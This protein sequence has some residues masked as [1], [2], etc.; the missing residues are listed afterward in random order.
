MA[1]LVGPTAALPA[2]SYSCESI[3]V[4]YIYAQWLLGVHHQ[5]YKKIWK[6][7]CFYLE[8]SA[9]IARKTNFTDHLKPT[10]LSQ[11]PGVRI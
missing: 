7:M 8:M 10:E 6:L 11:I 2:A 5:Q 1:G 3:L 9:E 4:L